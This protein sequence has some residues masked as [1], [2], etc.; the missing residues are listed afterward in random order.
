MLTK[1][2]AAA[3][4]VWEK[5]PKREKLPLTVKEQAALDRQKDFAAAYKQ[6]DV[7]LLVVVDGVKNQN[8]VYTV[9]LSQLKNGNEELGIPPYDETGMSWFYAIDSFY[10][11]LPSILKIIAVALVVWFCL[12]RFVFPAFL[13]LGGFEYASYLLPLIGGWLVGMNLSHKAAP[14]PIAIGRYYR[15]RG[16][17]ENAAPDGEEDEGTEETDGEDAPA[18]EY[19]MDDEYIMMD[20]ANLSGE[21]SKP[22]KSET[23]R[24]PSDA[25]LT[26]EDTEFKKQPFDFQAEYMEG[27]PLPRYVADAL[28]NSWTRRFVNPPKERQAPS[29]FKMGAYVGGACVVM[30]VLYVLFTN[31]QET[32][33]AFGGG[34]EAAPVATPVIEQPTFPGSG[35]LT[36]TPAPAE[37][38]TTPTPTA[39]EATSTPAP[40][41]EGEPSAARRASS[42][43]SP[44]PS[45]CAPASLAGRFST[46]SCGG[47]TLLL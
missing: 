35:I 7:A 31:A 1:L 21:A 42:C 27:S 4:R 16:T 13:P 2:K 43:G 19:E 41:A 5:I 3:G 23:P 6:R 29:A 28:R 45:S 25:S 34:S 40:A 24:A 38:E 36:P 12:V 30:F 11:R 20:A 22:P 39:E 37:G 15:K 32:G 10:A 8:R 26:E 18:P 47:A 14:F 46:C 9:R 17:A 33:V 44:S